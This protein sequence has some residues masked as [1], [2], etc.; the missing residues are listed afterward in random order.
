MKSLALFAVALVFLVVFPS[1]A[2]QVS[3]IS[4][5]P[6]AAP[7]ATPTPLTPRQ[8]AELHADI[9]MARKEYKEAVESYEKILQGEPNNAALLNKTGVA[10]QELSELSHAER[11]YKR[12][13]KVDSS[14]ASPVNNFGTVEY[15]KK[16][17]GKA[18]NSYRKALV[19]RADMSTIYSNLGYAYFANKEFPEAMDSFEKALALDPTIFDRRGGTGTIIQQRTTTDP[20]LFYFFVAK[21]YAQTGD[22]ERAAHYLKLAR[23]DGYKDFLAA[24]K[25]PAFAKVIKDPRVQEVL[26]VPPS[27]AREAKKPLSN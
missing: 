27:Y 15:E 9:L 25:D 2:Q 5:P 10:Y 11:C 13:I 17:Y 18:I 19:L 4:S 12:A 22:A 23:D 3:N 16:H 20:G 7:T 14:F 1:R 26:Q 6:T 8:S 24:E 21:T